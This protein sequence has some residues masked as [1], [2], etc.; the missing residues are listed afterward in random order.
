MIAA[1]SA[2]SAAVTT[3]ML[4]QPASFPR[5][6]AYSMAASVVPSATAPGASR[7]TI[8]GDSAH[9]SEPFTTVVSSSSMNVVTHTSTTV[10]GARLPDEG[11]EWP[12][13]E[14]V[15]PDVMSLREIARRARVSPMAP[16]RHFDDVHALLD[17]VMG[18]RFAR[19][20]QP[21]RSRNF[22]GLGR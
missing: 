21:S 18:Q 7:A 2:I 3:S 16:Y 9:A 22:R 15:S 8:A 14:G 1:T 10:H 17:E 13:V 12:G 5:M 4:V 11:R 20:R 6:R 19:D